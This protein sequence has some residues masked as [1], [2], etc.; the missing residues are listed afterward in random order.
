M[1]D[2]SV[3]FIITI[4]N[5]TI[6]FFILRAIL[7]KPVTKFMAERAKTVQ[8]SIDRAE[9]DKA[10]ARKILAEYEDKLKNAEAQAHAILKAARDNAA[11]QSELIVSEGKGEAENIIT[12]ARK[13]IEMERQAALT[14]FRLEAAALVM[15]ASSKLVSREFSAEDNRRYA[16]MLLEELSR[17]N[18]MHKGN[19]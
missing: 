7:F 18:L 9:K 10:L 16:N 17:Q 4:I 3:T 5:I 12:A 19:N 8:D 13:Q 2:F 6:L 15:A 11:R 1:L 14:K